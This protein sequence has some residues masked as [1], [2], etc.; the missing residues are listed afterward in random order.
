MR[1]P[2]R[3]PVGGGGRGPVRGR[4][5]GRHGRHLR[6]SAVTA[7]AAMSS[8]RRSKSESTLNPFTKPPSASRSAVSCSHLTASS[9]LGGN[10]GLLAS[11]VIDWACASVRFCVLT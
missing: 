6:Y 5:S 3:G 10:K 9:Q 1:D 2:G 8:K 4:D 7:L 11:S